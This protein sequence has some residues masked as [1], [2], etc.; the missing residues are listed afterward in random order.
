MQGKHVLIGGSEALEEITEFI[1]KRYSI[2][3]HLSEQKAFLA[4]CG[5]AMRK[6]LSQ[7]ITYKINQV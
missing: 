4:N 3:F 5:F 2:P 1:N 6:S 7:L